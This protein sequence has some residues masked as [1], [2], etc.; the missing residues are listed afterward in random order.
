MADETR[1][2]VP[3]S[4]HGSRVDKALAEL[5]G[6]SRSTARQ[7]VERGVT[8]SGRAV[9]ASEKVDAGAVIMTPIPEVEPELE[10][11]P[12]AF[13]VLYE[14][15]HLLVVDKPPGV[16]VHPGTGRTRGT[17]AG[18]LLHRYPD[19]AGV[20][21]PGRWGLIHRL[22]RDTS[23]ALLVA[24]DDETYRAL[25]SDLRHR[26]VRR[27]YL[28]LVHGLVGSATGTIDAPIGRDPSHPMKQALNHDGK[29]ARTHY[30]LLR[31]YPESDCSL[32]RV[33]LETGRTHQIRVHLA[34]I[35]HP[36]V[37]D[38]VYDPRPHRTK[39]PRTFLHA[40]ELG[41]THPITGE[42]MEVRSPLPP[43]L[44]ETLDA[45]G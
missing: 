30:E 38:F 25:V 9:D 11:E 27:V 45:L 22:D 1:L 24:R 43:D 42:R 7:L 21:D 14:D 13:G 36:V 31:L 3:D 44:Q 39:A 15:A 37:G 17:L 6:V 35:D 12:L 4:L 5:L 10:P 26:R 23:G 40:T 2:V 41:F 20:G 33:T 8:V 29:P 19:I 28:A 18:G 34:A 16:V 32:L